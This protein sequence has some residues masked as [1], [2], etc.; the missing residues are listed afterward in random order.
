M[1]KWL[2]L[3]M[4]LFILLAIILADVGDCLN[5]SSG[6][7]P[8][9]CDKFGHILLFGFLAFLVDQ[10]LYPQQPGKCAYESCASQIRRF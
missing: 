8:F 7:T 9:L 4:G 5:R 2:A 10:T 3:A 1:I 6:Y